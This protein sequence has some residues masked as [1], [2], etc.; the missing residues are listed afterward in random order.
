MDPNVDVSAFVE[1]HVSAQATQIEALSLR[2]ATE[3]ALWTVLEDIAVHDLRLHERATHGLY[4]A[5]FAREVT[6]RYYRSVADVSGVTAA[7]DLGKLV[8]SGMLQSRG[9]GRS[10]HYVAAPDLYRRVVRA[11]ELDAGWL[12]AGGSPEESRDLA[13]AGL[14]GRL[15]GSAAG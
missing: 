1:A 8:A 10:A 9:A 12:A 11:A 7:H 2:N 3:R 15:H 6:N 5:F 13:L 14:A 4:D